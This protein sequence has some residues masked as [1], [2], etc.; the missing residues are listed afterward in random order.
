MGY[1]RLQN[2]TG[3]EFTLSA[4]SSLATGSNSSAFLSSIPKSVYC[5]DCGDAI[6]TEAL[7]IATNVS[8]SAADELKNSA[9]Q[10]CGSSFGDGQL[11]QG[12]STAGSTGVSSSST[13]NG[14]SGAAARGMQLSGKTVTI[15]GTISAAVLGASMVIA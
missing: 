7:N 15:I 9:V 12:I 2:A 11:P 5:T 14:G 6:V 4:L 13:S 1:R 10:E 8:A 3:T